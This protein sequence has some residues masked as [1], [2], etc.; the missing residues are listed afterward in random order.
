M[1][2]RIRISELMTRTSV[3]GSKANG[4]PIVQKART[5]RILVKREFDE[6]NLNDYVGRYIMS[7]ED[8]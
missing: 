5:I 4:I 2:E 7:L 8:G 1:S 6:A 3:K